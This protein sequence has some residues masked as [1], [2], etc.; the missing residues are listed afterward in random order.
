M[1]GDPTVQGKGSALQGLPDPVDS[2]IRDQ[3]VLLAAY[4]LI[5]AVPVAPIRDPDYVLMCHAGRPS[6]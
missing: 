4:Q 2:R 1:P 5:G 6:P 3:V